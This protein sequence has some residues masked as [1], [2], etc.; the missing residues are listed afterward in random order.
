MPLPSL[1]R[2][3]NKAGLPSF[4]TVAKAS[5][6]GVWA[7][8]LPRILNSHE[9]A[10]GSATKSASPESFHFGADAREL[11]RHVFAGVTDVVRH[12][13]AE[14]RLRPVGPDRVNRIV[15]DGDELR[16]D[17]GAGLGQAL[18]AFDGVQPRRITEPPA[19]AQIGFDPG[20]RRP[21]DQMLDAENRAVDLLLR[22]HLIAAVNKNDGA[23]GEHNGDAG[24]S[25]EA[26][27]PGEPLGARRH[28]FVL[29]AVGA[30][31][32]EAVESAQFQLHAQR[33]YA[34]R[35]FAAVGA[36]VKRLEMRLKHG[37]NLV[38]ESARGNLICRE[39]PV[40][41][42]TGYRGGA[43]SKSRLRTPSVLVEAGRRRGTPCEHQ[44]HP[45][46]KLDA[47]FKRQRTI[48]RECGVGLTAQQA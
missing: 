32:D 4:G 20:R 37:G 18:G 38:H 21:L 44:C 13:L 3:T 22:L 15:F 46:V 8:S 33:R 41:K 39:N 43:S 30:R 2:S 25:G 7:T 47:P 23:V 17:G 48:G 42:K 19:G 10:C 35:R 14:R 9:I 45:T 1:R 16:I 31:Y 6:T 5:T 34:R 12:H 27:K 28:I 40:N 36:I 24:R 11:R 29:K 26:G